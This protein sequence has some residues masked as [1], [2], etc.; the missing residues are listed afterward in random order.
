MG[1]F[2]K[3]GKNKQQSPEDSGYYRA[4]DDR[5][6]TERARSKRASSADS[7]GAT[8]GRARKDA[9][10]P[11]LPEKKRARRRLVGAIALALAVAIGLPMVLDSEPKPL[12][13]DIAIQIPP[14]DKP[15][16][17]A[18]A[19][20][21][22]TAAE[23][24][25]AAADAKEPE[26]SL[27]DAK[28]AQAEALD[29]SEEI[30]EPEDHTPVVAAPPRPLPKLEERPVPVKTEPPKVAKLEVKPEPKPEAKPKHEP[31]AAGWDEPK[32][33]PK[34]LAEARPEPKKPEPKAE[35]KPEA[36]PVPKTDD[37][38]RALALLEGKAAPAAAPA[39]SG[40]Y[41]IQVAA[42][43]A[44]DKVEELQGKLRDAGIKSFTQKSPS[45]ELTRVKVGPFGSREEAEKAKAK[46]QKIGLS[47]SLS[48][49]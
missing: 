34:K 23:D 6:I 38:A 15:D 27:A 48:P 16:N 10:D 29:Q 47:G 9:P 42:L 35:A 37:A 12:N 39:D 44:K 40:R 24:A 5:A 36:K 13:N 31:K 21:D 25:A 45:G 8:R 26:E 41:V 1:L 22:D 14:R 2:S 3:F 46:L 19:A 49:A 20:A 28:T 11:V 43:A 7:A 30:V 33:E 17:S 32:V 18:K 4:A